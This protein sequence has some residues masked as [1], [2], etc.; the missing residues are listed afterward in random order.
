[1]RTVQIQY[2]ENFLLLTG[3]NPADF[4]REARFLPVL[5]LFELHR[6]SQNDFS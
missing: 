2:D 5:K 6:L 1:M 4:E 3:Q